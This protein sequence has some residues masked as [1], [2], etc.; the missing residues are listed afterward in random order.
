MTS[1]IA[2]CELCGFTMPRGEE[3]FKYHWYSGKCPGPPLPQ[4]KKCS[5]CDGVILA[6][7]EDWENPLC[8]NHY[9]EMEKHFKK[10]TS[11][12]QVE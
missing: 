3:M 10:E 6:D 2:K 7:T 5:I 4:K 9:D 12:E 8:P 11:R 1:K